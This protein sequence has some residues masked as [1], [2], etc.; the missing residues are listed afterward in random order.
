[1][2]TVWN[3]SATILLL[4][5]FKMSSTRRA[6]VILVVNHPCRM[7]LTSSTGIDT[8][9]SAVTP[10]PNRPDSYRKLRRRRRQ[11]LPILGRIRYRM[12]DF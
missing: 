4:E 3:E 2:S 6:I 12:C 10:E 7:T 5:G 9:Y 11:S 8:P 1:M